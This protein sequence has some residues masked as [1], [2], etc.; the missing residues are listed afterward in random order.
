M[1]IKSFYNDSK[2]QKLGSKSQNLENDPPYNQERESMGGGNVFFAKIFILASVPSTDQ[3]V[4]VPHPRQ[5]NEIFMKRKFLQYLLQ[6]QF[7]NKCMELDEVQESPGKSG[8]FPSLKPYT[9]QVD[10]RGRNKLLFS[11]CGQITFKIIN[12]LKSEMT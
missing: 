9:T 4:K 8:K 10:E 6:F 1:F 3:N 5:W 12:A 11:F 2:T 7:G